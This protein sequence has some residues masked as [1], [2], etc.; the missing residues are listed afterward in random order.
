MDTTDCTVS[1]YT[2]SCFTYQHSH[3]LSKPAASPG[4]ADRLRLFT[5]TLTGRW[6]VASDNMCL[7]STLAA[8]PFVLC[9]TVE[10]YA[11]G[12]LTQVCS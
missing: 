7:L 8:E 1:S 11:M 9:R 4:T 6:S 3:A 12:I 2:Y 5:L 10:G